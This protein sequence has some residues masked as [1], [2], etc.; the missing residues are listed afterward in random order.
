MPHL[1]AACLP[2]R[3][4]SRLREKVPL[5]DQHR[6]REMIEAPVNE[7]RIL[8]AKTPCGKTAENILLKDVSGQMFAPDETGRTF[9][10]P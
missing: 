8:R 1:S 7:V 6:R 5:F 10:K 3:R 9:G 2:D 4:V